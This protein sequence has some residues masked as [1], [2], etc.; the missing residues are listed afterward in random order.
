MA[1]HSSVHAKQFWVTTKPLL[2]AAMKA[3]QHNCSIVCSVLCA[4][5]CCYAVRFARLQF[6]LPTSLAWQLQCVCKGPISVWPLCLEDLQL[7][8]LDLQPMAGGAARA[9]ARGTP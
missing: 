2:R 7:E 8:K 9:R 6:G 1:K 3:Y 5:V 4:R